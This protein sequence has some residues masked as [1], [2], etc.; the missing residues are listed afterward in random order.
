VTLVTI[1]PLS[2]RHLPLYVETLL[3]LTTADLTGVRQVWRT[4]IQQNCPWMKEWRTQTPSLLFTMGM[5]VRFIRFSVHHPMF[6]ICLV[7][8]AMAKFAG[9]N[10][11]KRLVNEK[12][13]HEK[14]YKEALKRA[15]LGTDE[16]FLV[17]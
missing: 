7:G 13:Y 12:A 6:L 9:I 16:D 17:G 5:V 15:F 1:L 4:H 10:V 8:A 2:I 14:Q 3:C 11:H